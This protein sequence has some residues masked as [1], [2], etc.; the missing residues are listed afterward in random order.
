MHTRLPVAAFLIAAVL[1]PAAERAKLSGKVTDDKGKPLENATVMIFHA[2]VKKG[3][4]TF[5]PSCYVDCGKR[6]MTDRSGTFHFQNLAPDLWFELLVIHEGYT[7]TFVKRVDPAQG[8]APDAKLASRGQA[9][10]P[11]RAV[12]GRV[13]DPH[14]QPMRAAVITPQGVSTEST[15]HTSTYGEIAGLEPI[16]V[17][18]SKGEFELAYNRKADGMVILVEARGM[19]SRILAAPTGTE[20]TTITV[21]DGAVVRGRLTNHGKP[22]AGV[23]L[24]LFAQQRGAFGANLKITGD[25]YEEIRIG[26]QPDGTFVITNVPVPVNWYL[27][28]KMDSIAALGAT[29]PVKLSTIRENEEVNVGD[30]EIQPGYRLSGKVTLSDGTA[31]PN[32]MRITIAAKEGFDTQTVL[33]GTEGRFE[34]INVPRGTYEVFPSVRGY[35]LPEGK[36][37]VDTTVDRNRDDFA[38]TLDHAVRR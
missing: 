27:Y 24:G 9:S 36:F 4:S 33:L 12:R 37:T 31:I 35:S 25:P 15:D 20:R 17:T 29:V 38:V 21:S 16:A 6:T 8:P 30:I 5:C 2:G 7:A 11:S 22:V 32:G 34:F 13:V 14:G 10:D 1:S 23:Q 3:Y 19:A 28:G 26:T 18:N